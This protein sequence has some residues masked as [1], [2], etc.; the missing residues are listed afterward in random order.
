MLVRMAWVLQENLCQDLLRDLCL[1]FPLC[2]AQDPH[3]CCVLQL[4]MDLGNEDG[5]LLQ[6]FQGVCPLL[7]ACTYWKVGFVRIP[8]SLNPGTGA[9]EPAHTV[10]HAHYSCSYMIEGRAIHC[11]EKCDAY[12]PS[13]CS[14]TVVPLSLCRD[15][16]LPRFHVA[17]SHNEPTTPSALLMDYTKYLVI[18]YWWLSFL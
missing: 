16:M 18:H 6:D 9:L 3:H 14:S 15:S 7:M 13:S 1:H 17:V 5:S 10:V 4:G 12:R 11:N 8:G 2:T